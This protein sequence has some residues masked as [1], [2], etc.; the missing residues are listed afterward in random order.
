MQWS[1]AKQLWLVPG[2]A[3]HFHTHQQVP[4]LSTPHNHNAVIVELEM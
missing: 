1:D 3:N 4:R 2:F